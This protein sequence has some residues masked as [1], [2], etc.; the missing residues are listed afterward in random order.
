VAYL[1]KK[2]GP[3]ASGWVSCLKAIAAI[4]LLVK[5]ADK[6]TLGQ[7]ITVVAPLT[8]E[9][10]W[11]PPDWWLMTNT[12]VTHYQSFFVDWMSD[13]HSPCCPQAT[14]L[15]ETSPTHHCADI[16]A[17]ETGTRNDLKDQISL[18]LRVRADT[19]M[20]VASWLKVSGRWRQQYSGGQ[21]A[22]YLG[23]QLPWRD[24]GPKSWT[25]YFVISSING[26]RKVYTD[27]R[28]AFATV[29]SNIQTKRGVD[30][31]CRK[32]PKMLW[33]KEIRWQI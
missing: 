24:V 20:A 10:I 19:R 17:E 16:L 15:P 32:R 9:N 23:Q 11:K 29:W 31:I 13:L 4:A 22:S 26:K 27:S 3:V 7:Q 33:L 1:P 2:L 8:L 21:K 30:I 14:L 18:G 28:Y 5:D 6:L 12:P 25:R